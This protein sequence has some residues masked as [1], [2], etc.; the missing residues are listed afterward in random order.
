[1]YHPSAV[2]LCQPPGRDLSV[3][4][5][6]HRAA[7]NVALYVTSASQPVSANITATVIINASMQ[8]SLIN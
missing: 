4:A 8:L 2:W 6:E 1:M 3:S 7:V 5:A